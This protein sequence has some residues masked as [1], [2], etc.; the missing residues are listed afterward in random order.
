MDSNG[1]GGVSALLLALSAG[2]GTS[3]LWQ[4]TGDCAGCSGRQR[5][6]TETETAKQHDAPCTQLE[7]SA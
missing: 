4:N 3:L 5:G 1:G 2:E 6:A 7:T